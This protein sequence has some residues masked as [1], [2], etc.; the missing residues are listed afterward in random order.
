M[1]NLFTRFKDALWRTRAAVKEAIT[2]AP[3][4]E[5][6]NAVPLPA[7]ENYLDELEENLIKADLGVQVVDDLMRDLRHAANSNNWT[8]KDVEDFLKAHFTSILSEVKSY[9]LENVPN[10]L[11]IILVVGVNGTGKTTNIGKLCARLR[12]Q[13]HHVLIAAADTFRAAAESQLEIWAK[14]A[15]ADIVRLAESADPGAVVF[16]ALQKAKDENYDILVVDT[17]G[18]MHNKANLMAELKK[19]RSVIDKHAPEAYLESLLVIDSTTGQNGLQQAR[20]FSEICPLTGVILTKLDGSS[21]GGVV[22]S[23]VKELKIPVKLV[24]LGEGIDD[25][26]EF[27]PLAFVEA[28]F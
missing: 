3:E 28:L 21:K 12:S 9:K 6:P 8:S 18:R 27:E 7:D 25:L 4:S 22:F 19:V 16:S 15:N 17:A 1:N 5:A 2:E 26:K 14:R 23:I 10:K 20:V 24:G 11:N 13:G